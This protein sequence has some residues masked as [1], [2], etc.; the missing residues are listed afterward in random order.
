MMRSQ[1]LSSSGSVSVFFT[2]IAHP[3]LPADP[4]LPALKPQCSPP[5]LCFH[6]TNTPPPVMSHPRT[7]ADPRLPALKP[8]CSPP[9]LCSYYPNMPPPAMR[10]QNSSPGGSV[11]IFS[12]K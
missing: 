11:S 3:R 2:R 5:H 7:P 12:P 9:R 4:H 10:S 1:H 6:C 8:W